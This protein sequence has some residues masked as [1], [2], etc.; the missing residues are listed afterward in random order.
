M[1]FGESIKTCL[2]E[3]YAT[4]SGTAPRSEYWWFILF[5]FL[6]FVP[7]VAL[8]VA[9]SDPTPWLLLQFVWGVL[10]LLP[11][12][13]VGARRLHDIGR[14]GWWLLLVLVPLLG[15]LILLVMLCLP[16]KLKVGGM[17]NV[18]M[19]LSRNSLI[20]VTLNNEQ[21]TKAKEVNG[22]RKKITHALVCEG[23]GQM[24]G[25]EQQCCKYFDVWSQLFVPSVFARAVETGNHELQDFKTTPDLVN[26]LIE[27]DDGR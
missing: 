16:T 17:H 2:F 1:T 4:F 14:S 19:P 18:K 20:L 13:A 7:F 8:E 21:I 24:F 22:P 11:Q 26:I 10:I 6:S 5:T 12:I 23:Y 15:G 25:T 27:A 3:K 9:S